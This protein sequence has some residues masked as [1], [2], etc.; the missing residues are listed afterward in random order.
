M[1]SGT[2]EAFSNIIHKEL[3]T[4]GIPSQIED[5]EKFEPVEFKYVGIAPSIPFAIGLISLLFLL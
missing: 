2:A 5:L 4:I 1:I 3:Q